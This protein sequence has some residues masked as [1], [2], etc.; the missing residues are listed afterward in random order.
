[1]ASEDKEGKPSDC[2]PLLQELQ[3]VGQP[4]SRHS[5][6]FYGSIDKFPVIFLR[7]LGL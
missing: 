7:E 5:Q 4:P 2:L 1:M 3:I 6:A